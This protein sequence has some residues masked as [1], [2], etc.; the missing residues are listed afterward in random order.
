[1]SEKKK[2]ES[3]PPR[4][5]TTSLADVFCGVGNCEYS[6]KY[7]AYVTKHRQQAHQTQV[8]MDKSAMD[9]SV[10][11]SKVFDATATKGSLG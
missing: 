1:M 3:N 2:T 8:V 5:R 4:K 10:S 9:R 11:Y 6:S 7:N